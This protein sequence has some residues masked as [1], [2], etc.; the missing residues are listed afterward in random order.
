MYYFEATF[1]NY[2]EDTERT[3]TVTVD[4]IPLDA[5]FYGGDPEELFAFK[6][7]RSKA[8]KLREKDEG[9]VG[10]ELVAC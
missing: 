3:V 2:E 8:Y 9:L 7:A 4:T 1:I 6:E 10:I 5:S